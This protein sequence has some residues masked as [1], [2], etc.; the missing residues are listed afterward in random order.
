VGW[1]GPVDVA[2]CS[3]RI[4]EIMTHRHGRRLIIRFAMFAE[5]KSINYAAIALPHEGCREAREGENRGLGLITTNQ[6]DI[7]GYNNRGCQGF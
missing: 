1:A 3:V 4:S 5:K 6:W 7:T 2:S